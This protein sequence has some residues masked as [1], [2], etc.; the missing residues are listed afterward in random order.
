MT[1]C[2]DFPGWQGCECELD[3]DPD[4]QDDPPPLPTQRTA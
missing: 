2:D 1:G 4:Y 3:A